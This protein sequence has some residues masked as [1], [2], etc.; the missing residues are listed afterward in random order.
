MPIIEDY[1][2]NFEARMALLKPAGAAPRRGMRE[3]E[4]TGS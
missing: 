3:P 4:F 2:D 1:V